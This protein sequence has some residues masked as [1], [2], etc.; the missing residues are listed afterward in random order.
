MSTFFCLW[1]GRYLKLSCGFGIAG[2]CYGGYLGVEGSMA[3][4]RRVG[5]R[6]PFAKTIHAALYALMTGTLVGAFVF[7]TWPLSVPYVIST[8]WEDRK[9]RR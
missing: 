6:D 3:E 8:E 7:C 9:R 5:R 2:F 1:G 4:S